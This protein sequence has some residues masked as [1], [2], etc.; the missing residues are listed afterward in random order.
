M[1]EKNEKPAE[2]KRSDA[3]VKSSREF[4]YAARA[5]S[6]LKQVI[7]PMVFGK[8]GNQLHKRL[9]SRIIS[10]LHTGPEAK[11]G[12]RSLAD[13]DVTLMKGLSYNP[14]MQ[15]ST[16]APGISVGV[17]I[18]PVSRKVHL[19]V[20]NTG[21]SGFKWP[22]QAI[23]ACLDVQVVAMDVERLTVD[24]YGLERLDFG[25]R[26]S[27]VTEKKA[28]V[29]ITEMDHR[30]ILVNVSISFLRV[31]S[32]GGGAHISHHQRCHA[33]YIAAASYVK[34]GKVVEFKP[35]ATPSKSVAQPPVYGA[36]LTK[37]DES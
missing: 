35:D 30:L 34:D 12:K 20:R 24:T 28:S 36:A 27:D 15:F 37:W 2:Y 22:E 32:A 31:D 8:Y 3:S 18:D 9:Q 25:L 5:A 21:E 23:S 6:V 17:V 33:A 11:K 14:Y 10:V 4:G 7:L 29:P 19:R 16:L 13:G 1:S 26:D